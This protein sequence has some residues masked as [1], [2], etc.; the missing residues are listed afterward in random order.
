M[1]IP[2]KPLFLCL[3]SCLCLSSVGAAD[4]KTFKDVYQK[5]SEGITQSYQPKFAGVHTTTLG[6]AL[7]TK[8]SI[9]PA[10]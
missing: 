6:S 10:R 1:R 3:F 9:S 4:L 2:L 7:P 5:N 8:Y